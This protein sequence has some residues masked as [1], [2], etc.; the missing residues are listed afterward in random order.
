MLSCL[1]AKYQSEYLAKIRDYVLIMPTSA[2]I[3]VPYCD[4]IESPTATWKCRDASPSPA[5]FKRPISGQQNSVLASGARHL[6]RHRRHD[7]CFHTDPSGVI[8]VIQDH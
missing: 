7:A 1:C 4:D 5:V 3:G 8:A 2:E 6:G